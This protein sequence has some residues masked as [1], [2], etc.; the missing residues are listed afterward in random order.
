VRKLKNAMRG[1]G[2][3]REGGVRL[4]TDYTLEEK[5][6]NKDSSSSNKEI[7]PQKSMTNLVTI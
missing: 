2:K 6:R 1:G 7:L 3:G 5:K 4:E